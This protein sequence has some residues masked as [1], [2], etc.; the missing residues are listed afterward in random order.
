V[1]GLVRERRFLRA[2]ALL[3]QLDDLIIEVLVA[4]MVVV[5]GLQVFFRYVLNDSLSWSEELTRFFFAWM[6][7][8]AAAAVLKTSGHMGLDMTAKLPRRIRLG[9]A[10]A[11][12]V[13]SGAFAFALAWY[14]SLLV[15]IGQLSEMPATGISLEW[16]YL[17]LPV[18]GALYFLRTLWRIS[19]LARGKPLPEGSAFGE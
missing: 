11:I 10:L 18:G 6:V 13:V 7:F 15:E 5:M 8:I 2:L 19:L 3:N 4:V 14:G 17:S 12:E 1:R 16:A 9:V